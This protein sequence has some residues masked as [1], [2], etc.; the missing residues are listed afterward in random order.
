MFMNKYH[1]K[2]KIMGDKA[3]A[4][5]ESAKN[6]I[7]VESLTAPIDHLLAMIPADVVAIYNN[8]KTVIL[9]AAICILALFAFEGYK[10]FKML[11]YA[12]SAFGFA[13]VG[14]MYIAPLLAQHVGS[15]VP[16]I[17]DFNILVAVLCGVIA[18]FLTRF[19]YNFMIMV[20]GSAAGYFLG[21]MLIY[22]ILVDYFNTLDFLKAGYVKH[23]I[24]GVFAAILGILFIL[25]FKHVF[26]ILTSFGGLIDAALILQTLLVPNAD[27]NVKICFI[28]VGIAIAIFA[29]VRQYKEEEKAMEI[30]M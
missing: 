17:I 26:M 13:Y 27:W 3:I 30:I 25:L 1:Y 20:L 4:L 11:I 8:Y 24:G 9:L 29:V 22:E 7:S 16:E 23:I 15:Y 5:L 2:R 10:L 21:S 19:A 6:L 14:Y 28:L 18:I 12:G